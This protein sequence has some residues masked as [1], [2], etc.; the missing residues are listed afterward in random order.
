MNE[1]E[2]GE[3]RR[4]FRP[5]KSSIT[6]VRGCYVN[7]NR[8]II[9]QF[10]QSIA[11]MSQEEGE[12]FLALLRRAL[13]GTVGRNLLDITFATR[14]VVE[15][16]EHKLLMALRSSG[17]KDEEAVQTFFR[18]TME[19]ITL[20]DNYLILLASDAY[21]VPH[22]GKDGEVMEDASDQV[23]TYILCAVCPVKQTKPALSYHVK[24]NTFRDRTAEWLVSPPELGFLFP[25]FDQRAANLYH[26][27][28]YTRDGK[29]NHPSFAQTLFGAELP[30]PAAEQKEAFHALLGEALEE[31]CRFGV[32][33]AVQE[34]L[35]SLVIDHK[36][37]KEPEPL[38]ISRDTVRRVLEDSGVSQERSDAFDQAYDAAFGVGTDLSPGN[39]VDLKRTEIRT[40]D[41][42]IQVDAQREDLI[43]M[44]RINGARYV[45]I[46]AEE[47]ITV[48]GVPINIE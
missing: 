27:L 5:E 48:N 35:R 21:D 31:E 7:A 13:S 23:Y 45:L 12:K 8:E 40:G 43:E 36:E 30:L 2:I 42:V 41:V 38:V 44:R 26:T 15:G 1:K 34:E 16:E 14:Q 9:S 18:R 19:S 10:D 28:Y 46:R 33:Q 47:G 29:E 32:V 6:H 24:E 17:L 22:R 39:L 20:E 3:I 11:M 37:R 25:A 4:R